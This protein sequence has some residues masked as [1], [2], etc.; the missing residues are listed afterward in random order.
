MLF[1]KY[2]LIVLQ[3]NGK[4]HARFKLSKKMSSKTIKNLVVQNQNTQRFIHGKNI[5]KIIY[6]ARK[7]INIVTIK[8]Y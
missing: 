5:Y 3:I 2:L 8:K 4:L 6:I 7:I 1:N